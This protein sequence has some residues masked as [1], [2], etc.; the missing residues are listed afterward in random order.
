MLG[1]SHA[2]SLCVCLRD[3]EP[4]EGGGGRPGPPRVRASLCVSLSAV[5]LYKFEGHC[6]GHCVPLQV[7]RRHIPVEVNRHGIPEEVV[8][9]RS[10]K[11]L[12]AA[13]LHNS[14]DI[15]FWRNQV[16]VESQHD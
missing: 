2:A 9:C 14:M 3:R 8:G 11:T 10:L 15:A 5:F 7:N 4:G 12:G 6:K 13:F 16:T 1:A